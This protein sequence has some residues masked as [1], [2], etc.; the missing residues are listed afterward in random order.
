MQI[1]MYINAP[2]RWTIALSLW[3]HIQASLQFLLRITVGPEEKIHVGFLFIHMLYLITPML[4]SITL[5]YSTARHAANKTLSHSTP[6]NVCNYWSTNV[7]RVQLQ[8][9]P[10]E[11][12]DW[13]QILI[14]P[15]RLHSRHHFSMVTFNYCTPMHSTQHLECHVPLCSC[16][17]SRSTKAKALLQFC[18]ACALFRN[19]FSLNLSQITYD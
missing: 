12:K 9:K 8:E 17:S 6:L 10:D 14:T 5:Q 1:Y 7:N 16:P 13:W 15:Y 2:F 18:I 11:N 4:T 3:S 19:T